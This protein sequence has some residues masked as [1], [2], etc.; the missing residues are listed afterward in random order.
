[1][2]IKK[3][4]LVLLKKQCMGIPLASIVFLPSK[5][6]LNIFNQVLLLYDVCVPAESEALA[7][8]ALVYLK[9]KQILFSQN[10]G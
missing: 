3:L 1:M 7:L 4:D 2:V 9:T 8:I 10:E 5:V 6:E